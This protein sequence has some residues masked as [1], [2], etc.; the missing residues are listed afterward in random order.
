MSPKKSKK[1]PAQ[2][3]NDDFHNRF[4]E[5]LCTKPVSWWSEK[6]DVVPS[7]IN[8][9][10]KKGS[11]PNADNLIKICNLSGVSANWLLL[12]VGSKHLENKDMDEDIRRTLQGYITTLENQNEEISENSRKILDDVEILKILKWFAET[13]QTDQQGSWIDQLQ[14]LTPE[15]MF[16]RILT[17]NYILIKMLFDI[18]F[19]GFE[20][21]ANSKNGQEIL[22]ALISWIM[23]NYT[24]NLYHAK[25][26]LKDLDSLFDKPELKAAINGNIGGEEVQGS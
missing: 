4:M 2:K 10:W 7:L 20:Q 12:G 25:G 16:N 22:I 3:T 13:F 9:R 1:T 5:V 19:K 6:L 8:A 21:Y 26:S 17:P 18:V 15:E 23:E 14:K 11:Y 24:K